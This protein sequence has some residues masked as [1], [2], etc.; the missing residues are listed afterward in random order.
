[1]R[2]DVQ[3][4][5]AAGLPIAVDDFGFLR[6]L[7][8]GL[9]VVQGDGDRFGPEDELRAAASQWPGPVHLAVQAGADHFFEGHLPDL[10][11]AVVGFLRDGT[12]KPGAR[13]ARMD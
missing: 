10:R 12:P 3:T 4:L 1:V 2:P 8:T 13:P 11:T 6:E 5:V 7:H 9:L